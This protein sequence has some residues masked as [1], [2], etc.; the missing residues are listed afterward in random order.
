MTKACKCEDLAELIRELEGGL[1]PNNS[2]PWRLNNPGALIYNHQHDATAWI[3]ER[4]IAWARFPTWGQGYQALVHQITLDFT[5]NLSIE[6]LARKYAGTDFAAGDRYIAILCTRYHAAPQTR[7][8]E[9]LAVPP[10]LLPPSERGAPSAYGM[11]LLILA[12]AMTKGL[13]RLVKRCTLYLHGGKEEN[14]TQ[15]QTIE[16]C[17]TEIKGAGQDQDKKQAGDFNTGIPSGER[18]GGSRP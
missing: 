4:G 8:Q 1:T 2:L 18:F 10:P 5:R 7:L 9:F 14:H 17:Q 11:A 13:F 15:D 3:S 12:L 16:G 6:Q